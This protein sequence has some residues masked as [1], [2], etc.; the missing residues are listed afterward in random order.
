MELHASRG[1]V[2]ITDAVSGLR[3][4]Y[5]VGPEDYR[6]GERCFIAP[7]DYPL[8][9]SGSVPTEIVRK[10]SAGVTDETKV[11]VID[12]AGE[13]FVVAGRAGPPRVRGSLADASGGTRPVRAP[14]ACFP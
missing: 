2:R 5:A 10:E 3:L 6:F 1:I 13:S 14:A 9:A 12:L 11:F 7:G 8:M 4:L